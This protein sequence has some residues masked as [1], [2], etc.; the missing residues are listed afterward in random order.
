M[1]RRNSKIIVAIV[2]VITAIQLFRFQDIKFDYDLTKFFPVN[3]PET[4]FFMDYSEKYAW[5]DDF[6]L[7]GL[8]NDAGIFQQD[9]LQKIDSLSKELRK[10]DEITSVY[11][12]TT[13]NILRKTPFSSGVITKPYITIDQPE[14]Y[15][16][17]SARIYRHQELVDRLFAKDGKSVGIILGQKP[18]LG[19]EGCKGLVDKVDNL[20][21]EIGF[22]EAHYAGKCFSQTAFIQLYWHSFSLT[23]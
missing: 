3:S 4:D 2:I 19:V 14:K 7:I 18:K 17:D 16:S 22:K 9:F 13:I 15:S 21:N 1:Y 10:L 11:S 5:D 8:Y 12:P 20:I 6:V 23:L